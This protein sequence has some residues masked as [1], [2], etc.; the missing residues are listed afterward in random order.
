ML[1]I[2][3]ETCPK[4]ARIKTEESKCGLHF[5]QNSDSL[6]RFYRTLLTIR[7]QVRIL[8]QEPF[9]PFLETGD[10]KLNSPSPF[11]KPL[12]PKGFA[13]RAF[14]KERPQTL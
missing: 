6:E 7:S 10:P 12:V 14:S 13:T 11:V 8:P 4:F 3:S 9:S 2:G 5:E 1:N